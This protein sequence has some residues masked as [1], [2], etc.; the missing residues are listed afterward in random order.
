MN[1]KLFFISLILAIMVISVYLVGA[2]AQVRGRIPPIVPGPSPP[3]VVPPVP[4]LPPT[5]IVPNIPP[6]VI[7]PPP[8]PPNSNEP[9][10]SIPRPITESDEERYMRDLLRTITFTNIFYDRGTAILTAWVSP[11]VRVKEEILR[12]KM[13]EAYKAIA[14][15]TAR[16]IIQMRQEQQAKALESFRW[17]SQ[18]EKKRKQEEIIKDQDK[19]RQLE[20][21]ARKEARSRCSNADVQ[22]DGEHSRINVS[23]GTAFRQLKSI[24]ISGWGR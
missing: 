9:I 15:A 2:E 1:R 20:Q 16:E 7:G 19:I 5:V 17:E 10:P 22:R 24:S 8:P 23:T 13:E 6:S 21:E 14:E 18:E 3:P 12:R 4:N 11:S